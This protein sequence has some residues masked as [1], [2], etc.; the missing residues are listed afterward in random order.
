MNISTK[1]RY[2]L[3][4]MLDLAVHGQ[5]EPVPLAQIAKR[6]HISDGYLEQLMI[7]LKAKR[8]VK[9]V[10]GA[11]GGYLLS[12]PP[13]EISVLDVISALE[14]D[15][16]PVACVSSQEKDSCRRFEG[17]ATREM[18][19]AVQRSMTDT[20]ASYSLKSLVDAEGNCC[21]AASCVNRRL[22]S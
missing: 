18:W 6:Q 7:P 3:M 15:L 13:E 19:Q 12:R 16:A 8:L 1:G 22:D 20:M 5:G 11:Q 4:A 9:S 14:G 17:C 10:R 2:G 21:G